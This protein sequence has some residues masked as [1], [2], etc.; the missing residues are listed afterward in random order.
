[1]QTWGWIGF[2]ISPNGK[3]YP[4]DVVVGWVRDGI[5]HFNVITAIFFFGQFLLTLRK[6]AHA[7][8]NDFSRM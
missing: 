8:F 4:A 6:H 1:M 7:I 5:A 2:G 3:M